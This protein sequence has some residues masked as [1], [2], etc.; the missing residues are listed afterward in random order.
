MIGNRKSSSSV[1]I[2]QTPIENCE[3]GLTLQKATPKVKK[4]RLNFSEL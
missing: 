4:N 2:R 3:G 1:S